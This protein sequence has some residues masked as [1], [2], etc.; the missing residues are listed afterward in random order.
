MSAVTATIVD[1]TSAVGDRASLAIGTDGLAVIAHLD[2]GRG[3]RLTSCATS[4]C[5]TA[6]SRIVDA[7]PGVGYRWRRRDASRATGERRRADVV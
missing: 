7:V 1:P 4:A 5:G 2:A 3:L 6:T